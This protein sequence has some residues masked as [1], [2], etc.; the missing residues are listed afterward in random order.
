MV[1]FRETSVFVPRGA[2]PL[3]LVGMNSLNAQFTTQEFKNFMTLENF[4][5]S[6]FA[7]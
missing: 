5:L 7:H 6:G 3:V 1:K 4:V 2:K